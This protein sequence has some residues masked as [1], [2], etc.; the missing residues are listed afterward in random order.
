MEERTCTDLQ[1]YYDNLRFETVIAG[2]VRREHDLRALLLNI[3]DL[4]RFVWWAIM[5]TVRLS[6][7]HIDV[8]FCKWGFV[9]LPL[10]IAAYIHKIPIMVHESDTRAGLATRICG[11]LATHNF[12]GFPDTLPNSQVIGQIMGAD[13]T[14]SWPYQYGDPSKTNLLITW[15]SLW[16]KTMYEA[17]IQLKG[18]RA[19]GKEQE[20]KTPMT[21]KVWLL[22]WYNIIIV[23]GALNANMKPQ[24]EWRAHIIDFADQTTMWSLYQRADVCIC[25]GGTTSLAEMEIFRIHKLIVPL[26]I[27]HDQQTNAQYYVDHHRDHLIMQDSQII[28]SLQQTLEHY[29]WYHK[30]PVDLTKVNKK[31]NSAKQMIVDTICSSITP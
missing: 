27:T 3:V 29:V 14:T 17:V 1:Q 13:L 7:Y 6:R 31:I 11:R 26:P 9:S 5:M 25:R 8:V 16:A 24:F 15:W 12:S 23:L 18:Q 20:A 2:K 21:Y 28:S 10:T 4:F 30:S 22:T 19:K